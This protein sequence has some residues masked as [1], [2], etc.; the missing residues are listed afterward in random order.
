MAD[1]VYHGF[2]NES[3]TQAVVEANSYPTNVSGVVP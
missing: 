1:G 2:W 3:L